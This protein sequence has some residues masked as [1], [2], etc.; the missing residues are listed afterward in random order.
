MAIDPAG[1]P[2][3]GQ[4]AWVHAVDPTVVHRVGLTDAIHTRYDGR[5]FSQVTRL[6]ESGLVT[7]RSWQYGWGLSERGTSSWIHDIGGGSTTRVGLLD[8]EHTDAQGFSA[9][10]IRRITESG[11]ATGTS[12]R[13]DGGNTALGE[14]AWVFDGSQ[15]TSIVLSERSDGF[16]ESLPSVLTES[17][18]VLGTYRLFDPNDVDL[19]LRLWAWSAVDGVVDFGD[20]VNGGLPVPA[21]GFVDDILVAGG[22]ASLSL[23][24]MSD[25]LGFF[26][27]EGRLGTYGESGRLAHLFVPEPGIPSLLLLALAGGC[28]K[29]KRI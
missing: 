28:R 27:L 26:A 12:T 29:P 3:L 5:Q 6:K 1:G 9:T 4:S 21:W 20:Q 24:A 18:I 25:E 7:G 22:L 2:I 11:V 17:G 10:V 16:S 19:G 8:P 13:F 14:T 23:E 15:Q